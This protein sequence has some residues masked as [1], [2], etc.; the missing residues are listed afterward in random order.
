MYHVIG[1]GEVTVTVGE[2]VSTTILSVFWMVV[3]LHT[4]SAYTV[5]N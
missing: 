1:L 5:L 4:N 3:Q 2:S